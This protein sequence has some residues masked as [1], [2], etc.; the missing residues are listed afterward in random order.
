MTNTEKTAHEVYDRHANQ[1]PC[2]FDQS[3][4]EGHEHIQ[5]RSLTGDWTVTRTKDGIH[6]VHANALREG[7]NISK[8]PPVVS[9]AFFRGLR[10]AMLFAGAFWGAIACMCLWHASVAF[11]TFIYWLASLLG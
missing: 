7:P 6:Y 8:Q 1:W 3:E 10:Y 2:F 5:I 9:P 11:R 4:Y